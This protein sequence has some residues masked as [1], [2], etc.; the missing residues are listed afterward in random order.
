MKYNLENISKESV[1]KEKITNRNRSERTLDEFPGRFF[2]SFHD[3]TINNEPNA[4]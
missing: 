2:S 4:H 3:D 1:S